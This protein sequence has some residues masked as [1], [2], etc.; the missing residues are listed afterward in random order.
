M[1]EEGYLYIFFTT[2]IKRVSFRR[3]FLNELDDFILSNTL[4]GT[5]NWQ[6]LVRMKG[7]RW[8]VFEGI[9]NL[10]TFVNEKQTKSIC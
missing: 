6:L 4:K 2:W 10:F 8:G 1:K 7:L 3:G 9:S 5:E